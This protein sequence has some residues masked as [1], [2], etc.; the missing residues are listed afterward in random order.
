MEILSDIFLR[1]WVCLKHLGL[2]TA[3]TVFNDIV[4]RVCSAVVSN[5]QWTARSYGTGMG[6]SRVKKQ[7]CCSTD[8]AIPVHRTAREKWEV[9]QSHQ[10]TWCQ[11]CNSGT[12]AG[13]QVGFPQ[14]HGT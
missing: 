6:K 11:P 8:L 4:K 3:V 13:L 10:V 14:P 12:Q 7:S 1:H 5:P 9:T 2:I